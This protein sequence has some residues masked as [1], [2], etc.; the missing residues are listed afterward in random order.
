MWW[1]DPKF[2]YESNLE[3]DLLNKICVYQNGDSPDENHYSEIQ[4]RSLHSSVSTTDSIANNID[5]KTFSS[6]QKLY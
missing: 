2:L 4:K 3:N 6:E 5:I 1:N